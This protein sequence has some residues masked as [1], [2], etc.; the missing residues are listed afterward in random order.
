M[1]GVPARKIYGRTL[2]WMQNDSNAV[3]VD[4]QIAFSSSKDGGL[5]D[6]LPAGT[7]RFYQRDQHRHAAIHRRK[8]HPHTPMGSELAL[9]T[10]DAFDITVQVRGREPRDGSPVPSGRRARATA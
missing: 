9:K 8:R 7:V 10:G 3:N 4:S 1:Q 6:A 2:Y 5:G